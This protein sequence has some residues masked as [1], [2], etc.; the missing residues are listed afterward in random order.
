[1]KT[2]FHS[3]F[4]PA[5]FAGFAVSLSVLSGQVIGADSEEGEILT[6]GPVHE[7]FAAVVSYNPEAGILVDRQPPEPIEEVPPEEK[8]VGEDVAWIPG[9]WGWDDERNDFIW[10]S[11]TWRVLPPG[12]AWIAGYWRQA[13][14]GW[15][16]VSGYWE[17]AGR[18][19]VSYLPPPPET[20][21]RGPSAPAP[22]PDYAWAPGCWEWR[23]DR[24]AWRPGYWIEG[25]SEWVWIPSYY[26]WTPRGYVFVQGYWDYVPRERGLLFAP[27]Y[28]REYRRPRYEYR[29]S[30]VLNVTILS[31]HLF[32]RP[33]YCHYYFGDYYD[34]RYE[35]SGFYATY[36]Y[37]TSRF[38]YD[39]FYSH[40][41]WEHRHDRDWDRRHREGYD[42][43]RRHESGRPPRT[44]SGSTAM[45]NV[46]V[47]QAR[48]TPGGRKAVYAQPIQQYADNADAPIRVERIATTGREQN[49]RRARDVQQQRMQRRTL[50]SQGSQ[51]TRSAAPEPARVSTRLTGAPAAVALPASPIVAPSETNSSRRPPPRVAAPE[52]RE[53]VSSR[54][55]RSP[56]SGRDAPAVRPQT[57]TRPVSREKDASPGVTK[58]TPGENS[59]PSTPT[60]RP[61]AT[62]S[63]NRD[64]ARRSENFGRAEGPRPD[65]PARAA[66]GRIVA[67][68]PAIQQQPRNGN[69][70]QSLRRE[71]ERQPEQRDPQDQPRR[72]DAEASGRR[73]EMHR[74]QPPRRE[75]PEQAQP[76]AAEPQAQARERTTQQQSQAAEARVRAQREEPKVRAQP[77]QRQQQERVG[78]QQRQEQQQQ[79]GEGQERA[80]QQR[81]QARPQSEAPRQQPREQQVRAIEPPEQAR[82]IQPASP[83][84]NQSAR[85]GNRSEPQPSRKSQSNEEEEKGRK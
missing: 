59:A 56:S 28:Y 1:M 44:W 14:R 15:Q 65:E 32:L 41:R 48:A 13:E 50:E 5:L 70:N 39:P 24:Y 45:A 6:R 31:D 79:R 8:P 84:Q 10:V 82:R 29:P 63:R 43:R 40:S 16:W 35:R 62:R 58:A 74:P 55:E 71:Q 23:N 75:L 27:V 26:I 49:I 69:E 4:V 42:Y 76:R 11:G 2:F 17:D 68:R 46:E 61:S 77:E 57:S 25:R 54:A 80:Q 53:S 21:E 3:L 18:R 20:L 47:N 7:A 85:P 81:N 12:R 36:L 72:P 67:P 52:P 34:S 22:S 9:Y 66:P 60:L 19:E 37:Q 51:P 38:G 78:A 83:D 64:D 33:R 30:I 73:E